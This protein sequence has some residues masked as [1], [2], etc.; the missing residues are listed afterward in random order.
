[1]IFGPTSTQRNSKNSKLKKSKTKELEWI[2]SV[3]AMIEPYTLG[4]KSKF[5]PKS[6]EPSGLNDRDKNLKSNKL[7]KLTRI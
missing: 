4:T 7:Q 6:A 1:V 2:F 3:S 5:T